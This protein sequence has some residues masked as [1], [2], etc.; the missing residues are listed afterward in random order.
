[1]KFRKDTLN[2]CH[3]IERTRFC[4]NVPREITQ[5]V[6]MK[7]LWFLLSASRLMLT[8]N[9]MKFRKDSFKGFQVKE[10]TRFCDG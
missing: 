10:R 7:K 9:N 2:G 8:N 4:D 1:M 6:Q 5:K 3:V